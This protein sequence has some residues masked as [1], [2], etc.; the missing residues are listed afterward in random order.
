MAPL[1]V[2]KYER[3][4][5]EARRAKTPLGGLVHDSRAGGHAQLM[6]RSML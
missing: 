3:V 5:M 4:R 6:W 1:F 2:S